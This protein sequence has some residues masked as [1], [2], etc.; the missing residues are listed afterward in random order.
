MLWVPRINKRKVFVLWF[1]NIV[2]AGFKICNKK[3]IH[4][5][6]ISNLFIIQSA[7]KKFKGNNHRKKKKKKKKKK[8][9]GLK[10]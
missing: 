6:K 10:R 8:L 4:F 1:T 2:K 9:N 3:Q 5:T 7:I